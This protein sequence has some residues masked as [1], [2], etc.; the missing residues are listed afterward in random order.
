MRDL[1]A[2]T[3][4]RCPIG[5]E[6]Y[7]HSSFYTGAYKAGV[8]RESDGICSCGEPMVEVVKDGHTY[9]V[10]WEMIG[11]Y[12]PAWRPSSR[13]SEDR[14]S[15]EAQ[16]ANLKEW[17]ESGKEPVRSVRML[18]SELRWEEWNPA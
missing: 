1:K 16:Y 14:A 12:D 15:I 4:Y 13:E 8:R 11:P 7:G 10:E 9:R 3:S 17:E 18:R 2:Y 5:G 6:S